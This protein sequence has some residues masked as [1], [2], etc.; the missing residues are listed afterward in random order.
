MLT[1][2]RDRS[3]G[4]FAGIIA[5][6]IIIPMA[7]WGI[8]DYASTNA[9]PTIVEIGEQKITQQMFQQRLS[10]A[11]AEAL[12]NNPD[13]ASSDIF[14]SEFYKRQVLDSLIRDSLTRQIASDQG[15]FVGDNELAKSLRENELFQTDGKF[16]QEAYDNFVLSQTAS[17]TIFENEV[18][19]NQ[20][21][22]QVAA[23][24]Q[25]STLVLPEEVDELLAIQV[26]K[27][28]FDLLTINQADYVEGIEVNDADINEYYQENIDNYMEPDR[29]S[30]SYVNLD[31]ETLAK[32]IELN[33]DEIRAL[34]DADIERYKAPESREVSHILLTDG[35]ESEQREKANSLI[36]QL[37]GGADFAELAKEH[38]KDPG[39]ASN[40][41]SLGEIDPGSM[42]PEFDQAA[43]SLAQGAISAPVKSQFGYH[44]VKVNKVIGGQIKPFEEA[45]TEIEQSERNR[46]AQSLMSER[47]ELLR[48]L[49]FEQPESLEGVA[50]EM[51][52][53]IQTT[54]LFAQNVPGAG[55][56]QNDNIRN[57]AFSEQV[58]TEGYNSE[59]IEVAGGG[60]VAL[61]KLEFRESEPKKLEDVSAAIKSELVNQRATQAAE[62]AGDTVLAKAKADWSS[63]A[64]DEEVK[65][66]SFTVSMVDR[67]RTVNNDVLREVFRT[68][69][70]GAAE[71]VISFTDGT[72]NFNVVRLNSIEAG[73]VASV[74]EQI[75]RSTR[76]ILEQ[77]NGSSLFQSYLDGL[78]KEI[79]SEINTDLL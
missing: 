55:I 19:D 29:V 54:A 51:D 28:G 70:D 8:G 27:R 30:I 67:N 18:R 22:Y 15:Y 69:L 73:D 72:G 44:I 13:L 17:K 7:F 59:P 50:E 48:N 56:L 61:R 4:W 74:D 63:L 78:S 52:L 16:N 37:N 76:R 49:V 43:F 10:N 35:S 47:V 57:T 23:G 3:T 14:S 12:R 45:K 46:L 62:Q 1:E 75:K 71:K 31:L 34:Y 53:T 9:D 39:S 11:Q 20:R 26:E 32:D 33:D 58:L 25:E 42:V 38:S 2:I 40:G 68:Q 79:E 66:E 6:L 5:A 21:A 60:Y 64:A 41:G 24:Y 36:E 77:R 65:I